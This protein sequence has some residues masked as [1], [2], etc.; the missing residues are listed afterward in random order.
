MSPRAWTLSFPNAAPPMSSNRRVH[1]R[2]KAE[3]QAWWSHAT[4]IL[5]KQA[6]VPHL[7]RCELVV[8][9]TPPDARRRDSDN[10][11]AHLLK[12]IKDG[13]VRSGVIDD[14]TDRYVEWKLRLRAP[15]QNPLGVW[16]VV[17]VI[18]ELEAVS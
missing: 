16:R 1:W 11:V 5:V 10:Y 12:P 17:A 6:H 18:A 7:D 2:A 8:Y 13:L 4:E 15:S 3:E 14:D 9:V